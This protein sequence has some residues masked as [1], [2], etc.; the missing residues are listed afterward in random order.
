MQLVPVL[1]VRC[2]GERKRDPLLPPGSGGG[3]GPFPVWPFILGGA[4]EALSLF[5]SFRDGGGSLLPAWSEKSN[6]RL[7]A[8][9]LKRWPFGCWPLS[10]EDLETWPLSPSEGPPGRCSRTRS[11][12]G[13][14]LRSFSLACFG[15]ALSGARPKKWPRSKHQRPGVNFQKQPGQGPRFLGL[16]P[17]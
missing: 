8:C 11:I 5:C 3:E 1:V 10:S 16:Q 6:A 15:T 13:A 7:M 4:R 9:A 12:F 2:P 14:G 17:R